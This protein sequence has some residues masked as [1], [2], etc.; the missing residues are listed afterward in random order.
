MPDRRSPLTP[1]VLAVAWTVIW[2]TALAVVLVNHPP[3]DGPILRAGV[4]AEATP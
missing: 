3:I 1:V 4:T 2:L